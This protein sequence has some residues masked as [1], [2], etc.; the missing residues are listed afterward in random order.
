MTCLY[1]NG[2]NFTPVSGYI[3]CGDCGCFARRYLKP[4]SQSLWGSKPNQN[5][6]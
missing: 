5:H 4:I 3:A 1:C 2:S 6:I